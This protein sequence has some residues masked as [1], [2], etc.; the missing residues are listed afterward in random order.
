MPGT[1]GNTNNLK[2]TLEA[3]QELFNDLLETVKNDEKCSSMAACTSK[4]GYYETLIP[5]LKDKYKNIDFE[6]IK[7]AESIIKARLIQKG[8]ENEY[9]PT[10]SIFILKNNHGMND[11][12]DHTSGGDKIST[13]KGVEKVIVEFMDFSEDEDTT[14]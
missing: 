4:L 8:L 9:N 11:K 6:P 1:I 10:M 14:E 3:A 7:E 12:I 5:Y 13:G 2:W